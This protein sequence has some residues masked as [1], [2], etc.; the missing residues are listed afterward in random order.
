M[1]GTEFDTWYTE[2]IV[3]PYCGYAFDDEDS[4]MFTH[5][6]ETDVDCDECG[7][8]FHVT[9]DYEVR[10]TTEKQEANPCQP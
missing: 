5:S 10:Y 7:K 3:C 1:S 4:S 8:R 9:A 2:R 6:N